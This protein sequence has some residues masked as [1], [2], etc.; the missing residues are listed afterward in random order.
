[1][2]T[3]RWLVGLLFALPLLVKAQSAPPLRLVQ[4]I[5]CQT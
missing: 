2:K 5:P 4:T 1:M 3:Y